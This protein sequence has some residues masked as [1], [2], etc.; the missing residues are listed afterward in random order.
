MTNVMPTIAPQPTEISKPFWDGCRARRLVMQKCEHCGN[1]AYYPAYMCPACT[2]EKMT[3][4][5]L[6]GRGRVHSVTIVHRP[7]APAFASAVPYAVA[8]IEVE[9]GPIM[10]SNIVGP[11]ALETKID[12]DVEV[13]FEDVGEVTLPRFRRIGR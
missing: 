1:V 3:W 4:T 12:D 6:S 2:S 9:E 13:V 11:T 8:L 5:E 10:M 7:A